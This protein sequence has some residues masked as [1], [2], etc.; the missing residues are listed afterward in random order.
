MKVSA[1]SR[2]LG[3]MSDPCE[4][5]TATQRFHFLVMLATHPET[6]VKKDGAEDD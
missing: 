5:V 6:H 2:A 4:Q 1:A 3:S